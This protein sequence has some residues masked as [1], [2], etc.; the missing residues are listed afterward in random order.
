MPRR[1]CLSVL[2]LVFAFPLFAADPWD[3]APFSSDAEALLAAAE[4]IPA[5]EAGV[6]VL[7]DEGTYTFDEKGGSVSTQRTVYRITGESAISGWSQINA[8]WAPWYQ[9]RPVIQARVVTKDG[10]VHQLDSGAIVEAAAREE[11][12]DIFSDNRVIRAPLPAVAVGSVV[13]QLITYK[14]KESLYDAASSDVFFFGGYQPVHRTRVVVDA[15]ASLALRFVNQAKIEP[16]KE[17]KDGR[18]R[19]VFEGGPYA[20]KE[21]VEWEVPFDV[22]PFPWIGVS[23]AESWQQLAKRYAEI[24]EKQIA[25]AGLEKQAREAIGSAKEKKEIV[26]NAL[27]WIQKRVRYAGVEVGESSVVPRTPQA[28]LANRYGDCKDKA[29][30]LVALLRQAGVK[31]H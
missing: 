14:S 13:E 8:P 9:E 4:A 20:P 18:Q 31:A 10:T 28:V 26:A 17:E 11:S 24:V 6:V 23:T 5:G 30:L 2:T 22:A 12:L 27:A 21:D 7:L 16:R 1:L 29:T 15:P 25:N 3:A 19:F